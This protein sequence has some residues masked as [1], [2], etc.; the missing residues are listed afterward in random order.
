[1]S[2]TFRSITHGTCLLNG[3]H[4]S[5]EM[6]AE[7]PLNPNRVADRR[8]LREQ[9]AAQATPAQRAARAAGAERLRQARQNLVQ[10]RQQP[11]PSVRDSQTG[12]VAG[13][14]TEGA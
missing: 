6:W 4:T 13:T 11:I 5:P 12:P 9:A 2:D 8:A 10:G 14:A 3:R 1:M 7:C